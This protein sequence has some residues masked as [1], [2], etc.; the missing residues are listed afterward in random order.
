MNK[1]KGVFFGAVIID[2]VLIFLAY[3]TFWELYFDGDTF[4]LAT[5]IIVIGSTF[6]AIITIGLAI[7]IPRKRRIRF[8]RKPKEKEPEELPQF[9]T[10]DEQEELPIKSNVKIEEV[11]SNS[12][13]KTIRRVKQEDIDE[14]KDHV[15]EEKLDFKDEM[16]KVIDERTKKVEEV[17]DGLISKT[18][19][20]EKHIEEIRSKME[21][22]EKQTSQ[23]GKKQTPVQDK[24]YKYMEKHPTARPGDVRK[25]VKCKYQTAK[26]YRS[27][28]LKNEC[29]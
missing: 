5:W 3:I 28:W 4:I 22:D 20:D 15:D 16:Q 10:V 8:R 19:K 7:V 29:D 1:K 14:I 24:I 26:K 2:I 17:V 23:N 11:I 27:Q 21:K 13:I 18:E 12:G 9:K 6:M 25:A